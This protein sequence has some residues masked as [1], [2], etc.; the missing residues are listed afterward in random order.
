MQNKEVNIREWCGLSFKDVA[1][2]YPPFRQYLDERG[3]I[4]LGDTDALSA[5]NTGLASIIA[6]I[7]IKVPSGFLVPTF[8]LRYSY[9]R[10]INAILFPDRSDLQLLE[11]GIGSSAIMSMIAARHFNNDVVAT[12]INSL[13]YEYAANNIQENDLDDRITLLKSTGGILDGVVDPEKTYDALITYPPVYPEMDRS[14]HRD[15]YPG[16][17]GYGGSVSEMI[18][19]G[20]DG[21][22]FVSQLIGEAVSNYN[23]SIKYLTILLISSDHASKAQQLLSEANYQSSIVKFQAGTRSRFLLICQFN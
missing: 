16:K 18:G 1:E 5:Y 22:E 23:S 15:R 11:I 21:F 13:S 9:V 2:K 14:I 7:E 4:D 20:S 17:R 8:C 3:K 12:E 19:G 6:R 10:Y